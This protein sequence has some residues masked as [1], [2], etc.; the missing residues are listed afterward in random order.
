[1]PRRR[2]RRKD[3]KRP[4]EFLTQGWQLLT[5]AAENTRQLSWGLAGIAAVALLATGFVSLRNARMRQANED[6]GRALG[7]FRAGHFAQAATQLAD[8]AGRWQSTGPGRIAALYA[9]NAQLKSQN[10]DAAVTAFQGLAGTQEWPS[11]LQQEVVIGLASALERKNETA[12]AATHYQQA[13]GLDG[14]YRAAA[15]LGEARC[16]EQMGEKEKVRELYKRF[17]LDFPDAPEADL[18]SAKLQQLPPAA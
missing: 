16:R 11:Y 10:L 6:L 15:I 2:F 4:D 8:V 9:A 3:L 14:P 17:Q 13:A 12:N 1:M 18:V 7:E 5:W